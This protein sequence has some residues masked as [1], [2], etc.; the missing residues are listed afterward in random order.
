[1]DKDIIEEENLIHAHLVKGKAKFY[2][3][4]GFAFATYYVVR[5]V[6]YFAIGFFAPLVVA[7]VLRTIF[8]R[9]IE[10]EYDDDDEDFEEED[11]EFEE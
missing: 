4:K 1:A 6:K 8:G 3:L 2:P 5:Y 11:L 9:K 7:I 10:I